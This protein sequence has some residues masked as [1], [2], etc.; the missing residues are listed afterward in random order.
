VIAPSEVAAVD[1]V[2]YEH[3]TAMMSAAAVISAPAAN[4][5]IDQLS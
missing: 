3:A 4:A 5:M 2:G 1:L